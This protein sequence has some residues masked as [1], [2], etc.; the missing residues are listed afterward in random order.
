MKK[1]II[2]E[3]EII[4]A[5]ALKEKLTDTGY[6]TEVAYDGESGLEKI[7]QGKP[8]LLILDILLPGINGYQV[9]ER[10][11]KEEVSFPILIV[12]N[13]GQVV[14]IEK[15]KKLGAADFIVKAT[16]SLADIEDKVKKLIG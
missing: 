5:D 2:I 4:L 16:L 7:E 8:D 1:I 14:D 9:L 10:L 15:A 13:S 12:S 6:E 11:Q 3:D